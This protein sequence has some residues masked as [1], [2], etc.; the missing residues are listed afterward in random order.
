MAGGMDYFALDV[1]FQVENFSSRQKM[2]NFYRAFNP[3]CGGTLLNKSVA[4]AMEVMVSVRFV[5]RRVCSPR[6]WSPC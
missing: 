3:Q 1:F 5:Q 6:P 2:V 4:M